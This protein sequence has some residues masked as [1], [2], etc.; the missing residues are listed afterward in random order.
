[1]SLV[2][3]YM[4]PSDIAEVA[5]IDKMSFTPAWS[6]RSYQF[7]ISE[8]TYSYM[9]VLEQSTD[10]PKP[11]WRRLV[12][13]LNNLPGLN[14]LPGLNGAHEGQRVVAYGGM[15]HIMDEAHISTIATHPEQRGNGWGE[16]VLAGMIRRG[17]MLRAVQAVLEVRVSNSVAQNL[18]QKYG[19][20]TVATKP[21]YYHSNNEDA[22]EMH[23]NLDH[24]YYRAHFEER[25]ARLMDR[26]G[27]IDQFTDVEPLRKPRHDV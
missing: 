4:R 24:R 3:R 9:V 6:A 21:H 10:K 2:L 16:I 18:Y 13:G 12:P 17:M 5:A 8:S 27:F 15:W 19:F 14:S 11:G 23:L 22:Y 25:Y 20:K 1:M 7:E 26:H